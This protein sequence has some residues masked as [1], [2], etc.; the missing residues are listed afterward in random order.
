MGFPPGWTDVP[1]VKRTARLRM[2]GNAVHV[3]VGMV[4][5]LQIEG[6]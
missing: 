2:L 3:Q 1:G 4:V 5:G 6:L